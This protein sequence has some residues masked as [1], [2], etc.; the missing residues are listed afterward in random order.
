MHD[1]KRPAT[2]FQC[3]PL[4]TAHYGALDIEILGHSVICS[5]IMTP[6]LL[7]YTPETLQ[8]IGYA[9]AISNYAHIQVHVC[10]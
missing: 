3:A 4:P 2:M 8:K 10:I 9:A 7:H 5:T 6:L 1:L